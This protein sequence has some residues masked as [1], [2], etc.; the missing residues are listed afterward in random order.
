MQNIISVSVFFDEAPISPYEWNK[1]ICV[2][3][4]KIKKIN[5]RCLLDLLTYECKVDTSDKILLLCDGNTSLAI[6]LNKEGL[7][8]SRSFL[9][10]ESDLRVIE[11]SKQLKPINLKYKKTTKK[12]MYCSELREDVIMREYLLNTIN[13]CTN[14]DLLKYL[15]YVSFNSI[16]GYSKDKL[17]NSIKNNKNGKNSQIYEFLMST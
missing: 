1:S 3:G 12:I 4:M 17:I 16:K 6:R 5:H 2:S 7:I 9:N 11:L 14:T 10:Y 13:E 15:Y 8:T